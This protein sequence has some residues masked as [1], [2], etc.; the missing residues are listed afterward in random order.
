MLNQAR[1]DDAVQTAR[2]RVKTATAKE[3][4]EVRDF[5]TPALFMYSNESLIPPPVQTPKNVKQTGNIGKGEDK[6]EEG[7][8]PEQ[9][10]DAGDDAL[11]GRLITAGET[12][13]ESEKMEFKD[14]MACYQEIAELSTELLNQTQYGAR[15]ILLQHYKGATDKVKSVILAMIEAL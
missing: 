8:T 4:P 13:I 15:Q 3:T 9:E 5:G 10:K 7:K 12:V 1:V 2:S 14:K 11:V 6:K